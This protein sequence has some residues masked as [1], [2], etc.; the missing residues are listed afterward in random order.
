[1]RL[2]RKFKLK[3]IEPHITVVNC[4]HSNVFIS[5]SIIQSSTVNKEVI[6]CGCPSNVMGRN[7]YELFKDTLANQNLST[8]NDVEK[9]Q[10]GPSNVFTSIEKVTIPIK[11]GKLHTEIEVSLVDC[12]IPL[13][14]SGSQL[15]KWEVT[16]N[17][18]N[19]EIQIG[20]TEEILKLEKLETGH[21]ALDLGH[22]DKDEIFE[23]CF[24]GLIK[25]LRKFAINA[26]FARNNKG[27]DLIPKWDYQNQHQLIIK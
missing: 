12:E 14:I 27:Q 15:E 18:S 4:V 19:C 11:L 1:M 23:L 26:I 6:D 20:L 9:F 3:I 22:D 7:W 10:F 5:E 17:Y 13:L 21:Y 16:Q 2:I 25:Q 24:F 8:R